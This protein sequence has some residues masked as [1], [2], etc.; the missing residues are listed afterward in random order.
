MFPISV[1]LYICIRFCGALVTHTHIYIYI[2][3]EMGIVVTASSYPPTVVFHPFT[4]A[5]MAL[6]GCT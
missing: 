6:V 1:F 2:F 4:N 3:E 5:R